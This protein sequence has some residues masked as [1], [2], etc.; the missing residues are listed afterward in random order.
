VYLETL[1]AIVH[2]FLSALNTNHEFPHVLED[3]MAKRNR[4]T[5]QISIDKRIKAGRGAGRLSNYIPW[6]HIQDVASKGLASRV[7]GWKTQRVHHFMS[8]LELM[9]FYTLEWAL[10]V[11]DIREQF[12][13]FPQRETMLIADGCGVIHPVDPKTRH[14]VVMTTDFNISVLKNG[15]IVD[16]IRTIKYAKDL[17]SKRTLEK[18][19]IERRYFS[20]RNIDWSIVTEK[21]ISKILAKNVE[22]LHQYRFPPDFTDLSEE[23]LQRIAIVLTEKVVEQDNSLRSIALECDDQLGLELGTSLSI[24]RHLLANRHWK[25]DL[26][27]PLNPRERLVLIE[28]PRLNQKGGANQ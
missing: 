24:S 1:F 19:E 26:M 22:W 21:D 3:Y 4:N 8:L 17:R 5:T 10:D 15:K 28:L 7:K 14:P 13:L 12:P 20:A 6:L 23:D 25:V 27:K 11:I 9:Y 18:L 16:C 2:T